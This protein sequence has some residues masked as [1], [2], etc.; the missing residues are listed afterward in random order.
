MRLNYSL[1]DLDQPK[2]PLPIKDGGAG[3]LHA[4]N[5]RRAR[6][7]VKLYDNGDGLTIYQ[8]SERDGVWP[9]TVKKWLKRL[10]VTYK[11][12]EFGFRAQAILRSNKSGPRN[13]VSGPDNQAKN[14]THEKDKSDDTHASRIDKDR[15]KQ[16]SRKR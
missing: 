14:E 9:G 3:G 13:F 11:P 16:A 8:I 1:I 6:E 2:R 5:E 12:L 4:W 7:W 10:G 15:T